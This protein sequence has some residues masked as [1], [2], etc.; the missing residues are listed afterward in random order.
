[1]CSFW[2]RSLLGSGAD[3]VQ[4]TAHVL[5][6]IRGGRGAAVWNP[7][8]KQRI[9]HAVCSGG[10]VLLV[11]SSAE[12]VYF[13][14]DAQ[15]GVL[16]ELERLELGAA[17]A[18]ALAIAPTETGGRAKW[19]VRTT[20]ARFVFSCETELFCKGFCGRREPAARRLPSS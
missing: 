13:E 19:A 15:A 9:L 7:P 5:R 2:G 4:A 6:H 10:Q 18:T 16:L 12:L 8:P 17:A 11:L 1:V 20:F 14:L 3:S